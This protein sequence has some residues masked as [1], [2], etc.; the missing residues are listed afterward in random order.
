MKSENHEEA[1][2]SARR[3]KLRKFFGPGGSGSGSELGRGQRKYLLN[4]HASLHHQHLGPL[5]VIG[6]V[7]APLSSPSFQPHPAYVFEDSPR[8]VLFYM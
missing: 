5:I 6:V 2:P 1:L 4:C 3:R 7:I 8:F